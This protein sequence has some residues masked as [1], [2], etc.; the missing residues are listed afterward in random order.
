MPRLSISRDFIFGRVRIYG[1]IAF[2][3]W[4]GQSTAELETASQARVK[5]P[6]HLFE[7]GVGLGAAVEIMRTPKLGLWA[8]PMFNGLYFNRTLDLEGAPE[9]DQYMGVA[10]AF[11]VSMRVLI[12]GPIYAHGSVRLSYL[13]FRVEERLRH[14]GLFD[15]HAGAGVPF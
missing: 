7:L 8:G 4:S 3:P 1:E 13:A 11:D 6:Y 9:N 15:I 10:P 14:I 12:A 5:V 2:S